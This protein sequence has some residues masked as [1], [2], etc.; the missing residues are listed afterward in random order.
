MG[1]DSNFK[2]LWVL[3]SFVLFWV[4]S[5]C[6]KPSSVSS[7]GLEHSIVIWIRVKKTK[8]RGILIE[9][10]EHGCKKKPITFKK[11]KIKVYHF[12]EKP[13]RVSSGKGVKDTIIS[14][15]LTRVVLYV[16]LKGVNI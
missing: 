2:L 13:Y 1:S 9:E 15:F 5:S 7:G 11:G 4:L 10:E 16:L 12:R 14:D 6:K 8:K 3:N